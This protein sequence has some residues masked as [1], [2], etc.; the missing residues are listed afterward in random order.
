ML[1]FNYLIAATDGHAKN[2]SLTLESDGAHRLAPMYDVASIASYVNASDWRNKP[3]KLA[4]SIGGENRVGR[5]SAENI[6][7]MVELCGFADLGI[8]ADG[9]VRLMTLYADLIPDKLEAVFDDLLGTS[10]AGAAAELRAHMVEPI[11]RLC[12]KAKA[13]L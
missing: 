11:A 6:D 5:V 8:T 9:C 4:M 1:F 3:P 10:S 12:E 7:R 2:Y 13:Q